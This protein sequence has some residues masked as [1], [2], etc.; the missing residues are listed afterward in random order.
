M[1]LPTDV[2][3]AVLQVLAILRPISAKHGGLVAQNVCQ[4]ALAELKRGH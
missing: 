1:D 4:K 2:T 3:E